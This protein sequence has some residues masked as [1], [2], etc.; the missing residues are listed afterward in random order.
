MWYAATPRGTKKRRPVKGGVSNV[1]NA[2]YWVGA[3]PVK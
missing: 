1:T 3:V 2:P